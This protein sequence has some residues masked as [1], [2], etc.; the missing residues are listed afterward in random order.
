MLGIF[1]SGLGGLTVVREIKKRHPQTPLVYFGD[2]ARVPWGNKSKKIVCHYAEEAA[3]FLIAQKCDQIIIA[4]NTASALAGDHLRKK[5]K[6]IKFFDVVGP[7]I[8]RIAEETKK[9][10]AKTS[11]CVIGTKGTIKSGIYEKKIKKLDGNI[12][13]RSRACPLF[14]PLV[15]EGWTENRIASEIAARYLKDFV[16]A[17]YLILGCTHYPLLKKT[18][19]KV[20]GNKTKII[21]SAEE[22]ARRF[23][24]AT[25]TRSNKK[26]QD[27]FYFSD[28]TD[29]YEKLARKIL[30]QKIKIKVKKF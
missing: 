29:H 1:D 27:R 14:V 21:S 23:E 30:K 25:P 19:Q 26:V 5:F 17:N 3:G 22:V 10:N 6:K 20:L 11:V 7:V 9:S 18:I 16:T 15:E 24:A 8:D 4:C 28:W 2:T 13:I 12:K